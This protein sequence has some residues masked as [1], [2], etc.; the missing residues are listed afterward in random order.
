MK[1]QQRRVET[2]TT[3]AQEMGLIPDPLSGSAVHVLDNQ[4]MKN[5]SPTLRAH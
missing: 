1:L 3:V 4:R 5:L 2:M